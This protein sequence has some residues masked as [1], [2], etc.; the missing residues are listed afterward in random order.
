MA[1]EAMHNSGYLPNGHTVL[2]LRTA[3]QLYGVRSSTLQTRFSGKSASRG[4]AHAN[5]QALT[6]SEEVVVVCF[7]Q[8]ASARGIPLTR[9]TLHET[10]ELIHGSPLGEHWVDRF[11]KRHSDSLKIKNTQSLESCRA[12]ALNANIV[13]DFF[14]KLQEVI[15]EYKIQPE[16]IYNMDKKGV[17]LGQG[18]SVK[19]IVDWDLKTAYQ[20][21]E[22][23]RE[24]VTILETVCADGTALA[25]MTVFPGVRHNLVCSKGNAC[26][27]AYVCL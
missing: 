5:Q 12:R 10:A 13:G 27:S 1:I 14:E 6:P 7:S 18:Q 20:V 16:N 4:E 23:S 9:R 3:A 21:E 11:L 24:M 25:P 17:Q 15:S 26:E 2:S 22:G 8:E 19:A